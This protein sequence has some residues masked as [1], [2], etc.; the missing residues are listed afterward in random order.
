MDKAASCV[1]SDPNYVAP[2][3]DYMIDAILALAERYDTDKT[4]GG[5]CGGY[6]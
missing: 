1:D 2:F 5:S 6:Q 3:T 4:E